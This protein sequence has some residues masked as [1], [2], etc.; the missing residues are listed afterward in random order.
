MWG[1][2]AASAGCLILFWCC[3]PSPLFQ[4]P[5][6]FVL[7]DRNNDLLCAS[8][9]D[10]EQWRF[11][12]IAAV[13]EKFEKAVVCYEDKRFFIHPGVDPLAVIRAIKLNL[14]SRAVVSGAST[15]TM[16]VIRLSR[17]GK[18][19]TLKEKLIEMILAV[20]LEISKSKKEILALFASH[21][22]FG[23]NIVGLE[24]ASWRYF[25]RSPDSLSWAES[26]MLAVL[27]NSPSLVHPGKNR[28][29]LK[30]KRDRLLDTM[31]TRGFI[32]S[33]TC[34][35][36]KA[37]TLPDKPHPIPLD[38]LHLM[39][40]IQAGNPPFNQ[41]PMRGAIQTTLVR[42]IQTAAI[43]VISRHH[44][45]LSANNINNAAAL[46]MD[47]ETGHV[48]AYIGN[49][50]DISDTEH[51]SHVDV[52]SAPRSTGSILKPFLYAGLMQA[53]ELLPSQ[54]VPDI[55]TR[56]GDFAPENYSRT[57][58][59]AVPAYMALARSLNV[60]AVRLLS[61]YGTD[62]FYS[63]LK[64]LGMSSLSRPVDDY[65][66]T[67]ILGGAEGILWDI[68]AMYAD[69]ARCVTAF[70][71]GHAM[72]TAVKPNYLFQSAFPLSEETTAPA[73]LGYP[74]GP[75]A[76]WLTLQA[77]LKVTRPE[78]EGNWE[79]FTSSKKI[80][81]KT[82]TSYGYRDAWAVGVT[83]DYAV[84]VW[85][86]NADGEGR[87]ELTGISV[88]APILFDL[89]DLLETTAW[90]QPPEAE[91]IEVDVCANSGYRAGPQCSQTKKEQIPHAGLRSE[92]CPF[93]R[94]IHCD[95]KKTWQVHSGC[96]T[97]ADIHTLSWFV[98]PPSQEWFYRRKHSDYQPL[99][100]YRTDCLKKM[101]VM[102]SSSM[103]ILSPG[104]SKGIYV[105]IELD[106]TRG[107]VVFEAAHRDPQMSIFWHLDDTYL[108]STKDIHHMPLSP[109]PG[110]HNIT[111]VD[112]NGETLVR[113]FNVLNKGR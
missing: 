14:R 59:G 32:D 71:A 38:A 40:R 92:P 94:T 112:E 55:P 99:P 89:F 28:V 97:V 26:A 91:L 29:A 35:L 57:Y 43:R 19:R 51:G 22:P 9:A 109:D 77:M 88:A 82:G 52:I 95:A 103:T 53:G 45:K 47:V 21:A 15:L 87:P 8:L 18:P 86:G 16:Q 5:Y 90:F 65:G 31:Q 79:Q 69:M 67:L 7:V 46:I 104:E 98:L 102:K 3:L 11:P 36:A 61:A 42:R 107:K 113:K 80:A 56:I 72:R 85:V 41:P 6:S 81:W 54:L 111:L 49:I 75:A 37:E 76:C 33:L 23:G 2:L 30:A 78:E 106:G 58:Q 48:V 39:N 63:L 4:D 68:T 12:L 25:G 44:R 27:P 101:G 60:P 70:H 108:G 74:L 110:P 105:P 66:L 62:R 34:N 73:A 64:M 84:G 93:C 50:H 20:R 1:F 83:P 17:N 10:D 96:E 13:P 100:P 24:A